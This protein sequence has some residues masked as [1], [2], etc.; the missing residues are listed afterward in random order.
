[1]KRE[2]NKTKGDK[3][4]RMQQGG[5]FPSSP[6]EIAHYKEY[7]K[8]KYEEQQRENQRE[9]ALRKL[10]QGNAATAG[11]GRPRA[12][13]VV[14]SGSITSP[15]APFFPPNTP[16]DPSS[17]S[18]YL[19]GL[20]PRDGRTDA[21]SDVSA[22]SPAQQQKAESRTPEEELWDD[23]LGTLDHISQTQP[24]LRPEE[25]NYKELKMTAHITWNNKMM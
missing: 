9:L 23:L 15:T 6:E 5:G 18:V 14:V 11:S 12:P 16:S 25:P 22:R 10:R 20:T 4:K 3:A 1:M 19:S 24:R 7:M 21:P 8:L 17:P 2:Q 13:D